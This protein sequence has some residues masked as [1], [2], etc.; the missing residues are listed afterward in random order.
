MRIGDDV[1][2]GEGED[3]RP[4]GGDPPVVGGSQAGHGF[5]D[6]ADASVR[7]PG[8]DEIAGGGRGRCVVD[9]DDLEVR[10]VLGQQR[11]ERAGEL[12]G[13]LPG[14]DD[15]GG[16]G[17]VARRGR[18]ERLRQVDLVH[19]LSGEYGGR[20]VARPDPA[21]DRA[22]RA[23]AQPY[24]REDPLV[25]ALVRAVLERRAAGGG[26][27][28]CARPVRCPELQLGHGHTGEVA[29]VR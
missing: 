23:P 3:V 29:D 22:D 16:P 15:D 8:R 14:R 17:S 19:R 18:G 2:V 27:E 7:V 24:E 28:P 26:G 5:Q 20:V 1:V 11:V 4:G 21:D 10:V 12:L 9:D 25:L 13:A 6:V